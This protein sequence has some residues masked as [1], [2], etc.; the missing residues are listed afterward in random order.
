[1]IQNGGTTTSSSIKITFSAT[2]G[3]NPI[4]G[5]QCS[6]DNSPFSSCNS[7]ASFNN[8]A[9]GPHK[10]AVV[11][12]DAKGNKDPNPATFGWTVGIVTPTQSIQQLIQL[13]HSMHFGH[14]TDQTLDIRL[15][16]ALRLAQ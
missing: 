16:I 12:V 3:T 5:F 1:M 11:A 13:K 6:L 2:A 8:L 15:N 10:V 7:P 9:V 14:A 4:A